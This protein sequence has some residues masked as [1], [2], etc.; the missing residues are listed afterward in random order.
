MGTAPKWEGNPQK[1]SGR[2]KSKAR[3]SALAEASRIV[4]VSLRVPLTFL[5]RIDRIIQVR[6]AQRN[7]PLPRHSW[8]LEAMAEKAERDTREFHVAG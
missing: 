6:E 4:P 1:P 3:K 7:I 8:I 2:P 5:Q